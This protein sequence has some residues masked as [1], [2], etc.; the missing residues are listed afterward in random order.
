MV[1]S[2]VPAVSDEWRIVT[3]ISGSPLTRMRARVEPIIAKTCHYL[4]P[5]TNGL[6]GIETLA[7]PSFRPSRIAIRL[8]K[9]AGNRGA[10]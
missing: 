6:I 10:A 4:S 5:V 9:Q 8:K 3:R 7:G 2:P 1:I